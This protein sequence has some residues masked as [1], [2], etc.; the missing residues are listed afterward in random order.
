MGRS[1]GIIQVTPKRHH[2]YPNERWAG[3]GGCDQG[4]K[5][6]GDRSKALPCGLKTGGRGDKQGLGN[7]SSGS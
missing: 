4:G 1:L 6:C 3:R 5:Q 7:C 2:M